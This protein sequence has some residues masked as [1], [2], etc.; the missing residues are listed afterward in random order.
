[1]TTEA[2]EAAVAAVLRYDRWMKAKANEPADRPVDEGA[3]GV[4]GLTGH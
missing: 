3:P 2:R 1:M 4:V